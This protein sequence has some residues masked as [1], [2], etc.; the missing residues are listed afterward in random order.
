MW[1]CSARSVPKIHRKM[2]RA[3]G[4]PEWRRGAVVTIPHT[5]EGT[6]SGL[7]VPIHQGPRRVAP[8]HGVHEQLFETSL[9]YREIH[10]HGLL[11]EIGVSA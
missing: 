8:E 2:S 6:G 7:V 11:Q 1:W 5:R 3:L 4:P 10:E 9:V